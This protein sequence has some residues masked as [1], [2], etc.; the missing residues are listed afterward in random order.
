MNEVQ[1]V[2][3]GQSHKIMLQTHQKMSQVS[4]GGEKHSRAISSVFE[5]P[6]TA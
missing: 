6:E 2:S 4:P 1:A 5:A 3:A